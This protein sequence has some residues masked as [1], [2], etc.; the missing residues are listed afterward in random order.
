M[1]Q[2]VPVALWRQTLEHGGAVRSVFVSVNS[3]AVDTEGQVLRDT[4]TSY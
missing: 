1:Q 3:N 2:P 4:W